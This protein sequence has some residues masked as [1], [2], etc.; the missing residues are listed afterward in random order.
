MNLDEAE[1]IEIPGL[2]GVEDSEDNNDIGRCAGSEGAGVIYYF[3]HIMENIQSTHIDRN[4][5][6]SKKM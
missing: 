5:R 6:K 3:I 4:V 2:S 1:D